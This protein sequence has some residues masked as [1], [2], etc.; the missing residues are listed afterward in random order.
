MH[1][2]INITDNRYQHRKKLLVLILF[3]VSS[4]LSIA[5]QK[6]I[7][8]EATS[9]AKEIIQN[10][11]FEVS[12]ILKNANGVDFKAP[13]FKNFK[14]V[15]GPNPSNSM[16]I[17]QGYVSR[18]V[19]FSYTLSAKK[20]GV[21]KIGSAS[22]QANGKTLK[23][24]PLT[25]KVVNKK[26]SIKDNELKEEPAYVLIQPNKT[27]VYPG[28][29]I[30]VDYKLYTTVSLDG[31]DIAEEPEYKGFYVQELRRFNSQKQQ[32]VIGGKQVTTKVLRRI[33]LFPQRTGKL[34]IPSAQIQLAVIEDNERSGFFFSR[35]IKPIF[36]TTDP[37]EINVKKLP[38]NA[39]LNFTG[40]VGQ[41]KF[42]ASAESKH[43]TTDDV[44][45]ITIALIGDGD[46]KRVNTPKLMLSDSFEL[47]APKIIEEKVTENQGQLIG[48]KII[49]YLVLP[50]FPG[51]YSIQ[52]SF[53]FFNTETESYE[54]FT[55]GPYDLYVKKGSN[56]HVPQKRL[57]NDRNISNDIRSIKNESNFNKSNTYYFRSLIYL[58][59]V[60]APIFGFI[61]A[62]IISKSSKNQTGLENGHDKVKE[63]NKV[64]LQ[65]LSLANSFLKK[66]E[67]KAFYNEISKA[68]IGYISDKI[69]IPLSEISKN[70]VKEKLVGLKIS[71]SLINGFIEI[72]KTCEMSLFAGKENIN[73]MQKT[74]DKTIE[75]IGYIEEEITNKNKT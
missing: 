18:E 32:E 61:G 30:L 67:N 70:N 51:K 45:P 47:Y 7:T 8:F 19:G 24:I 35:N 34:T 2:Y 75:L 62:F 27:E 9:D 36:S 37:I 41:Y 23:S 40:A 53:S 42:Q 49:E 13:S 65:K 73:K 10:G 1:Y 17:I 22:I 59:L 58:F 72:L 26:N 15:S 69:G 25:I 20:E 4:L 71:E 68:S 31:Y 46:I 44:F 16:Q 28:E 60:V 21:F 12:F 39:P 63:A 56:K 38:E 11:Y 66:G 3:I 14:I 50:K 52:P 55:E 64:A 5:Q 57:H 29:Q 43:I 6:K 33:A 54:S 48:R 74:Y